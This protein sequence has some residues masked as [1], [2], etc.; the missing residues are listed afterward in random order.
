MLPSESGSDSSS[1]GGQSDPDVERDRLTSALDALEMLVLEDID[2]A[3]VQGQELEERAH[4]LGLKDLSQ[5]ARLVLADVLGRRGET[6]LAAAIERDVL[7]WAVERGNDYVLA[8]AQR[9]Q[10]TFYTRIGDHGAA[11]ECAVIAVDRLK[12]DVPRRLVADHLM[13][14]ALAYCGVQSFEAGRER[15]IDVIAAAVDLRDHEL[16]VR[17]LNNLAFLEYLAGFPEQSLRISEQLATLADRTGILLNVSALETMARAQMSMGAYTEAVQTLAPALSS[18]DRVTESDDIAA[19]H[20]TLAECHRMLGHFTLAA[21]SLQLAIEQ[22][23]ERE[24]EGMRPQVIEEQ[25]ALAAAKG[26]YLQAYELHREFHRL[27]AQQLSAARESRAR[28]LAAV[29]ET[30]QAVSSSKRYREMSLRDHLTGLYNR[31]YVEESLPRL[32]LQAIAFSSSLSIA[33]ADLDHFKR[34]NDL[35]SHEIGDSVLKQFALLLEAA[36]PPTGFVARLGGEEFLLVLPGHN[37]AEAQGACEAFVSSVRRYS[38]RPLV[39][40]LPVTVSV[41][42]VTAPAGSVAMSALLS[43]ADRMLYE[44]KRGGRDRVVAG[45]LGT[46][47]V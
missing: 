15:F 20:L 28:I 40:N 6:A 25:S 3:E 36:C 2:A 26:D 42:V 33:I 13:C 29:L 41:G 32:L 27:E 21:E 44:A 30:D 34:V 37:I 11:L 1:S 10:A 23:D 46:P 22:C 8:R 38:W 31:R 35:H 47:P 4:A 9:L 7:A 19:V 45:A 5:R 43:E 17:A 18:A 12:P 14:L 39:G 24:L 16:Q